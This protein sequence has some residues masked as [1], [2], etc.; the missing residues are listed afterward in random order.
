M[1]KSVSSLVKRVAATCLLVFG[2]GCAGPSVL[3]TPVP[4]GAAPAQVKLSW[5]YVRFQTNWPPGR[6]PSWHVDPMLAREVIRPVLVQFEDRILL[7]RFHR[8]AVRDGAGHQFSFIFYAS[9]DTAGRINAAIRSSGRLAKLVGAGVLIRVRYDDPAGLPRPGLGATSD[10]KWSKPMQF[11]WPYFIMGVSRSWLELVD[12]VS[13]QTGAAH[14]PNT[15]SALQT[16]YA[17]VNGKIDQ[18]WKNEGNHAYFHHL[19]AV[20][21]YQPLYV[22]EKSLR[23][24]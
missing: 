16:L 22:L 5:W 1:P 2:I 4:P 17:E 8:R 11:T 23:T 10:R 13:E 19:S 7:W 21:G 9:Q 12:M 15:V 6:Q 20:Y 14:P 3:P 24:F 18:T